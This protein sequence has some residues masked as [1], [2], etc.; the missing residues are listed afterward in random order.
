LAYLPETYISLHSTDCATEYACDRGSGVWGLSILTADFSAGEGV[1][2]VVRQYYYEFFD[3]VLDIN[4]DVAEETGTGGA[5]P[6][7]GD[8]CHYEEF[9]GFFAECC[10]PSGTGC[11]ESSGGYTWD[12]IGVISCSGTCRPLTFWSDDDCDRYYDCYQM[13]YDGGDCHDI[14]V[15]P[16]TCEDEYTDLGTATGDAIATGNNHDLSDYFGGSCGG[17]SGRDAAFYWTAPERGTY[18]FDTN[19]SDYW[20]VLRLYATDC[21]TNIECDSGSDG[22]GHITRHF[23]VGEDILIVVDGYSLLH[24]GEYSLSIHL[25]TEE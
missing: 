7:A 12:D 23:N 10:S 24:N 22:H 20:T 6:D 16:T 17:Y 9:C 19:D 14:S 1:L 18:T 13:D 2:I 21:S 3:V 5:H 15:L 8:R 4:R 25:D 11:T